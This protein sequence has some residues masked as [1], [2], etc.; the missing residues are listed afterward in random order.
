[1]ELQSFKYA[2]NSRSV[3]LQASFE[4]ASPSNRYPP[5]TL[6]A[7]IMFKRGPQ[8]RIYTIP[9]RSHHKALSWWVGFGRDKG[10]PLN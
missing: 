5:G 6:T 3:F 10:H 1:M 7:L 4:I 8:N 9:A 2:I